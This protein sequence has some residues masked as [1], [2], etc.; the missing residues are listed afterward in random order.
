MLN[1]WEEPDLHFCYPFVRIFTLAHDRTHAPLSYRQAI[2][3]NWIHLLNNIYMHGISF[4]CRLAR[5]M[6]IMNFDFNLYDN[7]LT[8]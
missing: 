5:S 1:S 8:Q 3:Q 6:K 2:L 7:T 4:G